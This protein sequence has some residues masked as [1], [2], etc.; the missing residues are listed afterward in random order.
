MDAME[1]G[2]PDEAKGGGSNWLAVRGV[3]QYFNFFAVLIFFSAV[4]W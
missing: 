2:T 4:K 3:T 1:H